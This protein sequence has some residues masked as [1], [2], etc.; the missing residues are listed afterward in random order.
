VRAIGLGIDRDILPAVPVDRVIAPL[1]RGTWLIGAAL[2]TLVAA[3][4]VSFE[5]SVRIAPIER[6]GATQDSAGTSD[7][8]SHDEAAS[9]GRDAGFETSAPGNDA[10]AG[11]APADD[12]ASPSANIAGSPHV[13]LGVPV[14][15]DSSDDY[16]IDDRYFVLSYNSKREVPNWVSW[17]LVVADLGTAPRQNDFRSDSLLPASF[18]AVGP[19]DYTGSGY[20]RG[21]MC[22]SGDRTSTVEANS[23]TFLMTNMQPQKH[24]LNAGPWEE[25]ETFERS[26]VDSQ[27]KQV[28]IMAGGI[29][30]P[31]PPTIGPGI[32]VPRANYKIVVALSPGQGVADVTVDTPLYAVIMPNETT[33][34]GTHWQ[35]Y[36]VSV[37]DI[38]KATGYDLMNRVPDAISR[39][40]E[41]K[42]TTPP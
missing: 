35:Q 2:S 33:V 3:C 18:P 36:A 32:A 5:A 41:A 10:T 19:T 37:D 6:D 39:V 16:W 14:D 23:A 9:I 30:D 22:P 15:S 28:F 4:S 24:E 20:D 8:S 13:T 17:R 31:Q 29:F 25:L 11:D 42:K 21:H 40:L 7:G 1:P 12:H 34:T 26:L 38:E 27:G